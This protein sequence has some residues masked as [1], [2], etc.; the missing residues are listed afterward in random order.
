MNTIQDL[1]MYLYHSHAGNTLLLFFFL[2][3]KIQ[4]IYE[5]P[6]AEDA[7]WK[8]SDTDRK[9]QKKI[10]PYSVT[11]GMRNVVLIVTDKC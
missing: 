1:Q 3:Y 11:F 9:S 8:V 5:Q 10:S 2:A 6:D 4:F 7:I